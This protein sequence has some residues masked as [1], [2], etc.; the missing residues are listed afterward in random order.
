MKN[1]NFNQIILEKLRFSINKTVSKTFLDSLTVDRDL[2]AE[3]ISD[4][5]VIQIRG[6]ILGQMNVR[7]YKVE[8]ET[9]ENWFEH[10]KQDVILCENCGNPAVDIHH[11]KF[12]SRGGKDEIANLMAICRKCHNKAHCYLIDEKEL[13]K[14]HLKNISNVRN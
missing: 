9:P 1:V 5:I 3:A 8:V 14:K 13:K 10:L 4:E 2:F 7:E 11:I 6:K 12:K